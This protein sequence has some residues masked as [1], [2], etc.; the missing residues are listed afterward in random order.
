MSNGARRARAVV[1]AIGKTGRWV[2]RILWRIVRVILVAGAA[3]G[4][5]PPPPPPP[6]V[7]VPAE[8]DPGGAKLKEE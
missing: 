2:L 4:P 1:R 5:A 3:M 8:I 7:P 6:P